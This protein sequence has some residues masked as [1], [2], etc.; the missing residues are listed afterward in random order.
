MLKKEYHTQRLILKVSR[1]VT[2]QQVLVYYQK[3]EDLFVPLD[4]QRPA[5]FLSIPYQRMVLEADEEDRLSIRGLKLWVFLKEHPDQIIGMV[6]FSNLMGGSVR[7]AFLAYKL[8]KDYLNHGYITE[9]IAMGIR[10]MFE[11]YKLNRIELAILP[12]NKPSLRVAEK[13]GFTREGYSERYLEINGIWEGHVRFGL[14]NDPDAPWRQL[15]AYAGSQSQ[16]VKL[17]QMLK[18][19]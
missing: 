6:S 2:P 9:A 7:S 1:L 11:V 16:R 3:N 13:L 17:M 10:I 12:R 14:I 4:P 15:P 5:G 18:K 19:S 8:D